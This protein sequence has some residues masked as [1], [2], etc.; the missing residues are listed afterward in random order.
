MEGG[1]AHLSNLI[2]ENGRKGNE[3]SLKKVSEESGGRAIMVYKTN[4]PKLVL[5]NQNGILNRI[6]SFA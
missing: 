5:E 3:F 1:L 4:S 6:E 2:Q